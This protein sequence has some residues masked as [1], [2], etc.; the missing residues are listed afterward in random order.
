[1]KTIPVTIVSVWGAGFTYDVPV[2]SSF[3]NPRALATAFR[4]TNADSRP[5]ADKVPSTS[6][7][8]LMRVR[9]QAYVVETNGFTEIG[10][11][12]FVALRNAVKIAGTFRTHQKVCAYCGSPDCPN[13]DDCPR[14]REHI[15]EDKRVEESD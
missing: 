8:D 12:A 10:E 6:V 4:I 13:P 1:M 14:R 11:F 9:G 15:A 2:P 7:G 3:S 5:H